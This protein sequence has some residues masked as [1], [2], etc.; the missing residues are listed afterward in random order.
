MRMS[1]WTHN[2]STKINAGRST[3]VR[4]PNSRYKRNGRTVTAARTLTD[5]TREILMPVR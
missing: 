3:M 1:T 5:G 2:R 4:K